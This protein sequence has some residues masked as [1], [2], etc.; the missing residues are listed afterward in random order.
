VNTAPFDRIKNPS[1]ANP[2]NTPVQFVSFS[3]IF[4]PVKLKKSSEPADYLATFLAT[5]R[6]IFSHSVH[7]VD[8][9]LQRSTQP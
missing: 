4:A 6:R 1:I 8:F 3:V 2:A 9:S 5:I 7:S